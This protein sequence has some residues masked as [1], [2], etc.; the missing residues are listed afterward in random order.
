[1]SYW[2]VRCWSLLT[3]LLSVFASLFKSA[4][5][6]ETEN[7]VM[8]VENLILYGE[9]RRQ[10]RPVSMPIDLRFPATLHCACADITA[11]ARSRARE[12]FYR[13]HRR[14]VLGIEVHRYRRA[15]A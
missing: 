5:L 2:F 12:N 4:K 14:E 7:L 9:R 3:L 6:L 11:R 15:R 13:L 1:M 8:L 10:R